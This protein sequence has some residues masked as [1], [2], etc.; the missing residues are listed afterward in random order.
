MKPLLQNN[1]TV[2]KSPIHGYGV[3]A[4]KNI[5]KDAI[6]EECYTILTSHKDKILHNY[7]FYAN[8]A[9]GVLTGFGFIYNHSDTPNADYYYDEL[10]EITLFT[11]IKPISKDEEIFISY[12]KNWFSDRVM[13]VKKMPR[14][15]KIL[16]YF[17][18][19]PLR[20]SLVIGGVYLLI[21]LL[22]V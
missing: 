14:W 19:I 5:Q 17:S 12:G 4:N 10:R 8:K 21:H 9:Y 6:I 20:A 22:R 3:F 11:A 7:Y 16:Q 2:K 18:G 1:L 15:L 13:R